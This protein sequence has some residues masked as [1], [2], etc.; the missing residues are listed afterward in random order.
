M[1]EILI[2]TTNQ[3][4]AKEIQQILDGLNYNVRTLSEFQNPPTV[5]EDGLTFIENATKKATIYANTYKTL[6]LADDS[7]LAV[8]ALN[9]RP[10]IHSARYAGDNAPDHKLYEKLLDELQ[11]IPSEQ[12]TARFHCAIVL[13]LPNGDRHTIEE[14]VNGIIIKEPRGQNGFGY[15]P[16]FYYPSLQKTFA[17]LSTDEK[18]QISHRAKALIK[19]KEYLQ[20]LSKLS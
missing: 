7:G 11:D 9:G 4:K 12:C 16:V 14:T 5:I 17:Q 13:I 10:G 6:T 8:D 20:N 18:N 2:A 1:R 3:H 19:V 15:D